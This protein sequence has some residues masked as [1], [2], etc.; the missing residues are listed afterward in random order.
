MVRDHNPLLLHPL[1]KNAFKI[2]N[3]R[4]VVKSLSVE[5]VVFELTVVVF[6]VGKDLKSLTVSSPVENSTVVAVAVNVDSR[7]TEFFHKII[8]A[9]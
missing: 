8:K 9:H 1:M 5:Q 4:P 6:V 2:L 7:N 3:L